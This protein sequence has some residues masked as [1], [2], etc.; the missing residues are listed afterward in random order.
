MIGKYQKNSIF[1]AICRNVLIIINYN[2]NIF[3][4]KLLNFVMVTALCVLCSVFA[5]CQPEKDEFSLSIKEVGA[6][7]ATLT[8]SAS[9]P[10]EI[11][12]KVT[13]KAQLVT[14]AVLFATG[15]VLNVK[16]GDQI[17]LTENIQQD[18]HYY[19]YAVAKFDGANYSEKV[20]L[21]F[22][23]TRYAFDELVTIVDTYL[24]GYKAHITVPE[25][26]KQR[27]HAIR[28][29]SMPLAWY[30][31]MSSS[32]GQSVVD[33]QA[34]A[35]TGNPYKGH[36]FNDSTIVLNDNN[37][38][39]LD[40]KG[41]PVLDENGEQIDIHDP[42]VP[43][44]P[45]IF[46][47]GE[48]VY[49]T[50]DEFTAVV[51]YQQPTKDS[52]AVPYYDP[53]KREWLGAFQKKEFFTKE[54]S[55]C[56]A[57]VEIEIP[58]DEITVTDAMIYFNMSDDAY[59]YFYMVLDN[60]TYNQILSTY[61]KGNEDWYRWFLTSYIAFYEWGIFPET[62]DIAINAASSFVEPLTGGD[63][64]HVLV[65]VFGD[66][67]GASQR[68]IHKTFKAKEKTK[69]A[70]AIEVTAI[71][72]E[73]PYTATF[74]IK[75]APDSKGNVQ[76]I[77]GAYWVCNYARDFELMFNAD[78][79]Y[80]TLLKNMGWT[81]APEEVAAI[82]TP[83]GYT[84]TFPFLDGE[85]ARFAAYGCNDEYTFNVI[86]DENTLAWADY[87][88]PLAP[89]ASPVSSALF[90]QLEGDWTATA[91]LRA[92]QQ[93]PDGTVLTYNV[94]HTSKINI[95]AA[96]PEL[97]ETLDESVYALYA[98][99]EEKPGKSREEVNNMYEELRELTELFTESRLKGQN[100]L[101]CSGFMDFDP[102]A[103]SLGVNRLEFRSPYD[104]FVATDYNSLDISQLLYDFG[105]KW[106]LQVLEDG[107]V[108]VPFSS[109]TMPPMH[110]WPGYPFYLGGVG[111]GVAFYDANEQY[112]GFPVEIS[113]D[114]NTITIKPI[115]LNDGKEDH[116]YYMNAI[117]SN[118]QAGLEIISTV[119]TEI[120]LK[121]GWTET[122]SA[123]P[124]MMFAGTPDYVEAV[125]LNGAYVPEHPKAAVCKSMTEF[126][127]GQMPA[128][129]YREKANVV[130][131][132]MVDE[133][134]ANILRKYNL[135]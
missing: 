110:N 112:P 132:D 130:T 8:V 126:K 17:R 58:E 63:T 99:T 36:M 69:V 33:L 95:S 103:P 57:T 135:E 89:N 106:Y 61:L 44:E 74:N 101:L 54:P 37:V 51:G 2:F 88:L 107:S 113:D 10:M 92:M 128:Y 94:D 131:K 59:S 78:Y 104:L 91:T 25:D 49:G 47:A 87:K 32:K 5:G 79:T 40:E 72:S 23:T 26:V 124:Q 14:P 39:L 102:A 27:G 115:V 84:V 12:Y 35:S 20:S 3:M 21:E 34:I 98:G 90:G 85:V 93:E 50:P 116:A 13:T 38:I 30:N 118:P 60:S 11:A 65:T 83:E 18:T 42:I 19:V 119:V 120:V 62:E 28:T 122:R 16:S 66:E 55:L 41:E 22:T 123:K 105:P 68:Y 67:S 117:G 133:A 97:P 52:W 121:R 134:S 24:D 75:A 96:A 108:I 109:L 71:P 127:A 70:P 111:D 86:D 81:F 1:A 114:L 7:Y 125:D 56:D 15:E 46:F 9:K 80:A 29:G 64:Y 48:T 45:T 4:K 129:N 76:P 31:L 53:E 6:D 82:N 77:M 43:G 100:R 73:D